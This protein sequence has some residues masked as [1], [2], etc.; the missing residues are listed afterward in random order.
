MTNLFYKLIPVI[1]VLIPYCFFL[2]FGR[3]SV[4]KF[5]FCNSIW[6]IGLMIFIYGIYK[7]K[8]EYCIKNRNIRMLFLLSGFFLIL[9]NIVFLFY[10]YDISFSEFF[11]KD[12]FIKYINH[13]FGT[14]VK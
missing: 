2:I 9:I 10:I 6:A 1:S 5:L 7:I 11:D 4:L 12:N 3:G 14:T 8:D 13:V